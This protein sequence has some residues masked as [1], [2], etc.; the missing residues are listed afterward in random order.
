[1]TEALAGAAMARGVRFSNTAVLGIE[2]SST[3]R[4]T[5]TSDVIES[6]AVV[7]ASGSWS[8]PSRPSQAPPITPIRGQLLHLRADGVAAAS[9]IWGSA[10]YVVPWSDGSVLVGATVED[11]GFDERST[12][13]GVRG[14][15]TAAIDLLPSLADAHF[16]S[17]RVGFRPRAMDELPIIGRSDTMPGVF[18]ALGHYRNGVLLAPLTAALMGD[19]VLDGKPRDEIAAI[20]PGRLAPV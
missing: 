9:V 7:V 2:G 15:L 8:V 18:Y 11:V 3:A 13:D 16:D 1:L 19:L 14:L 6:D 12:A 17:V 10:C 5:T 20:K 4:V